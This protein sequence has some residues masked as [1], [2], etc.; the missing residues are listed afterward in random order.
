VGLLRA[1]PEAH[2]EGTTVV[3]KLF[4]SCVQLWAA[5]PSYIKE[6]GEK[7]TTGSVCPQILLQPH[8]ME[9]NKGL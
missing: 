9:T 1:A 3:S 7:T 8:V 2:Q 5:V 6:V 4:L